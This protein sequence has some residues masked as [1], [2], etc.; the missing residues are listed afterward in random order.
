MVGIR[1]ST[2]LKQLL[3]CEL[4]LGLVG[5]PN[6]CPYRGWERCVLAQTL[7]PGCPNQLLQIVWGGCG[8]GRVVWATGVAITLE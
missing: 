4:T 8:H 7:H 6:Q 2:D 1:R 3:I 5:G